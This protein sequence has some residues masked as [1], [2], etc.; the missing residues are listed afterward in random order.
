MT[1]KIFFSQYCDIGTVSK[2]AEFD[3]DFRSVEKSVKK[4]LPKRD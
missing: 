1:P 3:G 4:V 2:N